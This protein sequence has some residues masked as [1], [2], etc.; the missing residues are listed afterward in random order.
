M[1]KKM[2]AQQV[3]KVAMLSRLDLSDAEIERFAGQLSD[4][5]TYVEKM[6]ELDT[7]KV[8]P[9]AH[10]LGITNRFGEDR[11]A[12]SLGTEKALAN[13]PDHDGQFFIVPRILEENSA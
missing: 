10:C 12:E 5:V 8:E 7:E 6:N 4:I 2:D 13:A 9:M 11:P 1:S 3:K